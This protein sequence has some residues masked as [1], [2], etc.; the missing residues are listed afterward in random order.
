ME[1]T[2]EQK[3]NILRHYDSIEQYERITAQREAQKYLNDTD[4]ILVKLFEYTLTGKVSTDDYKEI[5]K[6]REEMRNIL[7]E[8]REE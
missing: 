7:R 4:Y 8:I 3:A 5:F 6:K 2:D 1:W